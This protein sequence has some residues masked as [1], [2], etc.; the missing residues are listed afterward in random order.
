V[1][2]EKITLSWLYSTRAKKLQMTGKTNKR[3]I[4]LFSTTMPAAQQKRT[5]HR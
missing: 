4:S 1:R 2:H 5:L 3:M